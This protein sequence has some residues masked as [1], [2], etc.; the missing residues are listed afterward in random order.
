LASSTTLNRLRQQ[1]PLLASAVVVVLFGIYLATQINDWW[2]LTQAPA[3]AHAD[4]EVV[5][6]VAPDLQRMETLFGAP[7]EAQNQTASIASTDL[8]L[9]GSFVH[10]QPERSMAII[11]RTGGV[12][13]LYRPGAEL[14]NGVS[15]QAVYADRVEIL[16]NGSLETLYFPATQSIPFTPEDYPVYNEPTPDPAV[17]EPESS[18][19]AL[20]QQQMEALRQQL[21][22]S[23]TPP[24][25]TPSE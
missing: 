19:S 25:D 18:D 24:D 15:L 21:E 2:R 14:D 6:G 16:R 23:G 4:L 7:A 9:H 1:T 22:A 11:Q 3:E 17:G 8:T 12:P 20:L 13:E 10:A 5:A